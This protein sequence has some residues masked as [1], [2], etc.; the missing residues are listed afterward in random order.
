[1]HSRLRKWT[2]AA[3]EILVAE[4]LRL[5]ELTDVKNKNYHAVAMPLIAAMDDGR[6]TLPELLTRLEQERDQEDSENA[7]I[8]ESYISTLRNLQDSVDIET[9]L[10]SS[11]DEVDDV[12][13]ELARLNGLAQLG[14]T[15]EII[16]HEMDGLEQSITRGLNAFPPAVK[17][18]PMFRLV[19]ASHKSLVEKLR[20]LSPLKLSGDKV[21][22][23]ISGVEI[24]EYV[25]GFFGESLDRREITLGATDEF[26]RFSVY[27][28]ASRIY[29]V[30]IN[31]I[32]NSAYWVE[33]SEKSSKEILLD[34]IH[35]KVVI[36][37][38]GP[39]VDADDIKNLFTLFFTR[40]VRSGRGVGLYLCRANLAAGGHT[41]SYIENAKLKRLAGANFL[42][43]FKGAK[44]G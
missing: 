41:I 7:A 39:G 38:N 3:R 44:Y 28:Q 14:I 5:S 20:F 40:K 12:R 15:V 18:S 2:A 29:P 11:I 42:I 19:F 9:L 26:K 10:A 27:E 8:F 21:K 22:T 36:A 35:G 33:R 34:I 13:G 23:W 31:I 4:G 17:D 37:D 6:M 1:M 32:N 24:L 30:F 16:G 43:D 25:E